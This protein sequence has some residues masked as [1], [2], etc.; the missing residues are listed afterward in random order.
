MGAACWTAPAT[1]SLVSVTGAILSGML[2]TAFVWWTQHDYKP[3]TGGMPIFALD[4]GRDH[5]RGD[6][7]MRHRG[8]LRLV[9]LGGGLVRKRDWSSPVPSPVPQV[10]PGSLCLRVRCR[11]DEAAQ[12]IDAMRSADA[13]DVQR[14]GEA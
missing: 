11:G 1:L 7:A 5:V 13:V 10:D 3:V 8:E 12:A 6:D 14:R 4:D 2:A 9:P